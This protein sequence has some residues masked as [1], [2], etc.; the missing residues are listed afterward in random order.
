MSK[1]LNC[2]E[3]GKFSRDSWSETYGTQNG[4]IYECGGICP[5]HG[6]WRDST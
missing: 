2:P 5:T 4:T 6:D 1:A 3:C